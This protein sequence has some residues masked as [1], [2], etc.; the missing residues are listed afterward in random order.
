MPDGGLENYMEECREKC[1]MR[2]GLCDWCG[3]GSCC[4]KDIVERGCGGIFGGRLQYECTLNVSS[5]WKMEF[6]VLFLFIKLAYV[7]D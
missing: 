7:S 4:K 2:S 6:S 5:T 3:K 1:N